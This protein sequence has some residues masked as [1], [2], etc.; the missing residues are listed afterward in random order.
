MAAV[1]NRVRF[2]L[3]LAL[4]LRAS[5]AFAQA[6]SLL[7]ISQP[8]PWDPT[9]TAARVDWAIPFNAAIPATATARVDTGAW[10]VS[11]PECDPAPAGDLR[12]CHTMTPELKALL[13]V[14]G[15]HRVQVA[16]GLDASASLQLQTQAPHPTTCP[17]TSP[18]GVSD[19]KPVGYRMGARRA[20]SL[21][22]PDADVDAFAKRVGQL[23]DWRWFV[24]W[25]A[26]SNSSGQITQLAMTARC[27]G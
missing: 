21:T 2:A 13:D 15:F 9:N 3:V 8:V 12:W 27:V 1:S 24:Q 18:T 7:Y 6:P 17:Y 4:V 19:P 26:V 20:V 10:Q 25:T 23:E 5:A 11:V 16:L 14:P 22:N